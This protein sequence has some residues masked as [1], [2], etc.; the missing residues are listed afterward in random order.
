MTP[1]V[2]LTDL[3]APEDWMALL[4]VSL[5]GIHLVRPVYEPDGSTITDFAIEY[6]NPAAQRMTG[7][8]EQPGGT[9]LGRFP[10]ALAEGIFA[11]YQRVFETG[12]LLTYETN[13]QA[14]GLDNFFKLS[15]RRSGVHL[16]VSFTDTSDQDR[17][18]VEQALRDSQVREQTARAE[19]EAERQRF[20]QVLLQLP[21]SVAINRGPAHVYELVNPRYQQLFR[22]RPLLGRPIREAVPEL[23]GQ[24]I[25]EKLD[26]VYQTGEAH[27][28]LEQETWV[29][30]TDSGQPERRF[31]N[32][33]FHPLRDAQDR[34]DGLLNFA[35]DVTDQVLARQQVEHLNQEL[36]AR[37]QQRTQQTLALQAD[38]LAAAQRQAQ[39][40]ETF[41]QV[42]EQTPAAICI[43]RGPAHRYEYANQAYR[44]FFPGRE[45]LGQSVAEALPETVNSGVVAL[46]DHVYQTGE[47]YN[48]VELP[49]L[50]AQPEGPPRQMYFTFTYQALR[51]NGQIVGISTFAYNV[52]EQV[53][54]RQQGEA[55]RQRL[56]R[57]FMQ[58]P[59][60][61]CILAGTDLVYELVN[62]GY[63][64]LF[65]GRE[66]LGKPLLEALPEIAD[67]RVYETFRQVYDMGCSHEEQALLIP[68]ARPTDGVLE[69]RYFRYVQ[70]PRYA[71]EGRI[72]GV[73]VFAFEVTEQVQARQAAEASTR[74]LR[75]ITDALP[76]LIGYLDQD[77]KY[78]FAN[79][80]YEPWFNV[81]AADLLGRPIREV[82]GPLAYPHIAP[83]LRR[84]L[85]GEAVEFEV[86]MPFR[87]HFTKH[88]HTSYIPDVQHGTVRG[89]YTLVTDVTDQVHARQQVQDLNE[90]LAA[91][92]EELTATNAELHESN[93][94]LTR[95]NVELDTFVYTASHD[96]KAP[97]TNIEGIVLALRDTLPAPVQQ[98]EM[99]AHLLDLLNQTVARFQVTITQLTDISR[100]QLAHTGLAEPVE[101]ARVVEDVRLDL[102]PA[103]VAA[104]T[105]LTVEVAP[106]LV[107]SFSP[108]NLR[109]IV[110]NLLSN[111]AKYRA[112]DRPSQVRIHAE[113]TGQGVVLTVQ[114]NGLGMSEVQQRQLFGLF[115]RLHTHV[116]GTG[117]GLYITKRL[118][119]NA[120]GTIA[121]QSQ[122]D[123]G[124]TFTVTF[125]A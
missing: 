40:R 4:D 17:S 54:A 61:I 1:A 67:N 15:A 41:Y 104:G 71:A 18:A 28:D 26:H 107:V 20:Y 108:A 79:R 35:Y 94:Q 89:I 42:F 13:Y 115:Q 36:E 56:K 98:D 7:L 11:Y 21:A 64:A 76:V 101:L 72:D 51:E 38:L 33:L 78:R 112:F 97:I 34:V 58:A 110:Y 82:A 23:L 8:A 14:D 95:T 103:L 121:V 66:L 99:V 122:P 32:V 30:I 9:L 2:P 57:L 60:A 24:G 109:S 27:Y 87:P 84:A 45:I 85:A 31:Y 50:I 77:E 111:A 44:D 118:I 117:V 92:N 53:Y 80:A 90:K 105:Q 25:L 102:A 65:P 46:L 69:D 12:E 48:G 68:L 75:L 10:H 3:F 100:L 88:I 123:A 81:R 70:Q 93:T 22:S 114:D 113:Q 59:A 62:P 86:E 19:A 39:A 83:Y 29:D 55:E 119:E 5:T 120:G 47:T 74:Q 96:L 43:Q 63:Q 49:L 73:L 52:A 124:T 37:V 91:I 125:P 116:E 6:L 16:L 106:E